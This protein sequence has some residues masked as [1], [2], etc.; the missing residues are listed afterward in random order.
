M[1][2]FTLDY[3][4]TEIIV[5]QKMNLDEFPSRLVDDLNEAID[6]ALTGISQRHNLQA[7]L[8]QKRTQSRQQNTGANSPRPCYAE[9]GPG[10][11]PGLQS[12]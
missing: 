6:G 3:V 2:Q 11:L 8:I 4:S 10:S 1:S 12:S 9:G 5:D 7:S